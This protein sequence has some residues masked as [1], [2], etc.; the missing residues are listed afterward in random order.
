MVDGRE[1]P[2]PGTWFIDQ[3]NSQLEVDA[4]HSP[5]IRRRP[6]KVHVV[7]DQ[8]RLAAVRGEHGD[9]GRCRV[10]VIEDR[11]GGGVAA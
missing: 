6:Q 11:A 1:L 3:V 2:A 10:V 4:R 7:A 8:G 5:G 9:H